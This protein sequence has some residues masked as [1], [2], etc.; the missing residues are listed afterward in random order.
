[1]NF[2]YSKVNEEDGLFTID[3]LSDEWMAENIQKQLDKVI[4]IYET[5]LN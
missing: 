5:T 3:F 1:M 2:T 4:D